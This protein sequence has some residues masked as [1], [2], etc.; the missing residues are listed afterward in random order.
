MSKRSNEHYVLDKNCGIF[1]FRI[2]LF[3][4]NIIIFD[5]GK[6]LQKI[7][8][9]AY[10]HIISDKLC[11]WSLDF[12]IYQKFSINKLLIFADKAVWEIKKFKTHNNKF[13]NNPLNWIIYIS[14]Y[15]QLYSNNSLYFQV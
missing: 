7:Q 8:L 6:W 13:I 14:I 12:I 15:Q 3:I 11:N 4:N 2:L 9:Q 5:T 1:K 10:A